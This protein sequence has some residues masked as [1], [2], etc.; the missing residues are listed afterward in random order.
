[1]Q[2]ALTA[3]RILLRKTYPIKQDKQKAWLMLG[4]PILTPE[5]VGMILA[6]KSN[7]VDHSQFGNVSLDNI[8]L[9]Q[10]IVEK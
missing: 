6:E 7:A 3:P 1:M 9:M 8:V 10:R 2:A 4:Y 5:S